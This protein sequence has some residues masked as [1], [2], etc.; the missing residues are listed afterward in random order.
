MNTPEELKSLGWLSPQDAESLRLKH[1][2]EYH[3]IVNER[4]DT[5]ATL[6]N[7]VAHWKAVARYN[8]ATA[9]PAH[10]SLANAK[11]SRDHDCE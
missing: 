1:L 5:V 2:A 11:V 8:Q 3:A 10:L 7:E 6:R 4:D 9:L